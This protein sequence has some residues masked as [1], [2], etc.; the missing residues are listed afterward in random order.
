MATEKWNA[1]NYISK[2]L[3]VLGILGLAYSIVGSLRMIPNGL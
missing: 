3:I 2:W 1:W